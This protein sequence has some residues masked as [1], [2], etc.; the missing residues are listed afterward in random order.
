MKKFIT[1]FVLAGLFFALSG[2]VY[3]Q[4]N[5]GNSL[6]LFVKFGEYPS[7]S[8]NYEFQVHPD[9]TVS[10]EARIWFGGN[11]TLAIGARGDY[12]FDRL[13]KLAEPWDIWGGVDAGFFL[14]GDDNLSLNLHAGVEYKFS[15]TFGVIFEF[16]G[17]TTSAGGIGIA[18]HL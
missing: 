16:G 7:I 11:N 3:A 13:L 9:I 18:L 1:F 5:H 15:D 14:N 4:E 10:P 12:Y 2:K 8:G 6:N 17:G